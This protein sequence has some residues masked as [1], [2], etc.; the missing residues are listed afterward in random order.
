MSRRKRTSTVLETARHRFAGLKSITKEPD[1]G[2]DL[3]LPAYSTQINNFSTLLDNY[4]GMLATLDDLQNSLEA[5]EEALNETN[6]R[7]LSATEA[8]YGPDSSEYEQAGGTRK[9][10]RKRPTKK[11]TGGTTPPAK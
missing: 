6:R 10:E 8:H 2:P 3:T 4:N 1:F 7:M 5:A 11:G 9:S